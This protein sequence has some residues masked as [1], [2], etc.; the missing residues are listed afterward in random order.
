MTEIKR[1][2][3][4]VYAHNYGYSICAYEFFQIVRVSKSSMWLQELGKKWVS[5]DGQQGMV[6]CTMQPVPN[7]SLQMVRLNKY[8]GSLYKEG[9][10]LYEDHMD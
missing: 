1:E 7:K 8:I 9:E 4:Q 6:V 2:V 3:G 5:G 10:E